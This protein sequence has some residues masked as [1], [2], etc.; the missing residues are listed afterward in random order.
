[1]QEKPQTSEL[2]GYEKFNN[3]KTTELK[4]HESDLKRNG[5]CLYSVSHSSILTNN[6][7]PLLIRLSFFFLR[8]FLF[9]VGINYYGS[10]EAPKKKRGF[11]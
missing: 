7:A 4:K 8:L 10:R 1:M 6:A 11:F 5:F 2:K 9:A 3:V